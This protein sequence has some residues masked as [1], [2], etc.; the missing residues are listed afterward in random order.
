MPREPGP[1]GAQR[2][3]VLW[4]VL[5]ESLLLVAIGVGVGLPLAVMM[6]RLLR[7]MLYGVGPGD[8]LTFAGA[9]VAVTVVAIAAS[10]VPAQRAASTDPMSAL[11]TE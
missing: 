6:A 10:L 3:Q 5:R 4:M 7:S 8:L 2:R 1:V 9:L 11:R